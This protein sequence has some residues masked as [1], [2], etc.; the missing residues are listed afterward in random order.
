MNKP[1]FPMRLHVFL[2]RCGIASRRT[3]EALVQAGRVNVNGETVYELGTKV[4]E[5]DAVCFDGKPVR[6]ER[7]KVYVLLHKPK[8]YLCA[9]RDDYGR[10]L[11]S[12]LL[13]NAYS[14]RLYNVGRLDLYSS[15]AILFT[16]DGNF[17]DAIAHPSGEIEKEYFVETVFP[18]DETVLHKFTEGV[19]VD[20]VLYRCKR[21]EKLAPKKM[22]ITLI[23]GK[24]REIRTVLK[25]FAIKVQQLTRIRIGNI[26]LDGL[27][28]GKFRNL[29]ATEI[30]DLLRLAENAKLR[31]RQ[32]KSECKMP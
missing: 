2:A 28:P 11:A 14:E 20:G 13:K 5:T 32:N 9:L 18:F 4:T 7:K 15:G 10:P 25:H 30:S 29:T 22:R 3:C 1:D 26:S 21:A 16:N 23:E 17:A 19:T 8:G 6:I 12:D 31:T 27:A 24:N